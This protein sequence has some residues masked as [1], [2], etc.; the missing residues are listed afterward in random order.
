MLLS[1]YCARCNFLVNS[2][3]RFPNLGTAAMALSKIVL[4]MVL[5][6][7]GD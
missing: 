1:A 4:G 7:E 3:M 6:G 2:S 5:F